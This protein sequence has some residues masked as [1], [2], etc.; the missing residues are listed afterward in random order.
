MNSFSAIILGYA[1]KQM[2]LY[3]E[4]ETFPSNVY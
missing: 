1:W 2:P 4:L 3:Y